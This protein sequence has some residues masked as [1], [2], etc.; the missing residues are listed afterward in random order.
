MLLEIKNRSHDEERHIKSI[1]ETVSIILRYDVQIRRK[2]SFIDANEIQRVHNKLP[3][4]NEVEMFKYIILD[5]REVR[6][7]VKQSVDVPIMS[8]K[9]ESTLTTLIGPN[10]WHW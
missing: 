3:L 6:W 4:S 7:S 10:V 2:F 1:F 9:W 8:R 5:I